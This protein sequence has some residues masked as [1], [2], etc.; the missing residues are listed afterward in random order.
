MDCIILAHVVDSFEKSF[1]GRDGKDVNY[2]SVSVIDQDAFMDSDRVFVFRM[3]PEVAKGLVLN[4]K[5]WKFKGTLSRV[6]DFNSHVSELKFRCTE[7]IE[8]K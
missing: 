5:D 8:P 3:N 2:L 4:G 7:V 6:T 1:V